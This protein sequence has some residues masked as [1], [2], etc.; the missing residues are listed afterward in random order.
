MGRSFFTR[1]VKKRGR[2]RFVQGPKGPVNFTGYDRSLSKIHCGR[3]GGIAI[4]NVKGVGFKFA[5]DH[6]KF[7]GLDGRC[8][9]RGAQLIPA[10]LIR[11]VHGLSDAI[12]S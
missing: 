4:L 3:E 9:P 1:H 11:G 12:C 8:H 7:I 5:M 10:P 6:P 2:A